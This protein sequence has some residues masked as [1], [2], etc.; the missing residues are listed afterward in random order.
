MTTIQRLRALFIGAL[1]LGSLGVI[2]AG[3]AAASSPETATVSH[4]TASY[5]CPCF[6]QF[7][8]TGVH[9]TN[10]EFPGVD[11]GPSCAG[12]TGGRDNFYGSV[13]QPPAEELV[14][15]GPGG[16]CGPEGR[17]ESDY[18]ANLFTCAWSWTIEPDGTTYGWAIYP[19]D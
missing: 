18:N 14:L 5:T 12:T 6:G 9:L 13:S 1:M 19:N 10:A 17:W 7:N 8:L 15:N 2:G 16:S 4:Y 3:T 11:L